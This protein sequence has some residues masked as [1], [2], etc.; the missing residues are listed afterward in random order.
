MLRTTSLEN[1]DAWVAGELPFD[2]ARSQERHRDL[3]RASGSTTAM[4]TAVAKSIVSTF[5]GDAPAPMFD[6]PP[7]CW[8]HKQGNFITS[9]FP[10]DRSRAWTTT[11]STCRPWI[12]AYGKP[13]LVAG[14]IYG[15]VQRPPGCGR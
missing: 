13:F 8:L 14:D 5:F 4:S 15:D 2:F 6:D 10:T 11:S 9:F 7:K 3:E 12:D 1:Y